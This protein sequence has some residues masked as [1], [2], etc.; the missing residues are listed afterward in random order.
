M[1]ADD[2]VKEY[3]KILTA[4]YDLDPEKLWELWET[5]HTLSGCVRKLKW[6]M[7]LINE[8]RKPYFKELEQKLVEEYATHTIYPPQSQILRALEIC[9]YEKVRV[10]IIGQDPYH[11]PNMAEGLSFSIHPSIKKFPSSLSN[12]FKELQSDLGTE[13]PENGSLIRWAEQGVLLLY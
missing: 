7:G 3:I 11:T 10:V 12:I 6:P 4:E 9:P 13:P 2:I 5:R 1:K 8:I